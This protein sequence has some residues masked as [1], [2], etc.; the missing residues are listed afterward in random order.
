M[1][2]TF[3]YQIEKKRTPYVHVIYG[4][5]GN[6]H[7]SSLRI[8]PISIGTFNRNAQSATESKECVFVWCPFFRKNNIRSTLV[9]MQMTVSFSI[10]PRYFP[11]GWL[12][13]DRTTSPIP[14]RNK[15]AD[16]Q[17]HWMFFFSKIG[18]KMQLT[19][20]VSLFGTVLQ[21]LHM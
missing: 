19:S 9:S 15:N 3:D 16:W 6:W 12:P 8:F 1:S 17:V 5:N 21:H 4:S 18:K 20:I 11:S 10:F 2:H 7:V 13:G 14:I